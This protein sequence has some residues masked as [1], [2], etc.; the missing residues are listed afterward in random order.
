MKKFDWKQVDEAKQFA[1]PCA[2]GYIVQ[3]TK[4][5][6]V[7]DREYLRVEFDFTEGEFKGY[8]AGL[9]KSGFKPYSFIRSYKESARGFF[10]HFLSS[11][12]QCN[13]GKFH[14]DTFDGN[15]QSMVGLY[16]GIVLREEEYMKR[17]GTV[18][19]GTKVYNFATQAAIRAKDYKVPPVKKL[20][21]APAAVTPTAAAP[22]PAANTDDCPF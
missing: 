5:E 20:D 11:L 19:V 21:S 6:D 1:R 17:D 22:A 2:G 3:I 13:P 8:C 7:A 18:G 16:L 9:I 4:V 15:E 14:A 10:K 12:E